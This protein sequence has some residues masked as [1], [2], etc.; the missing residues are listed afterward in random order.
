MS[1]TQATTS[2]HKNADGTYTALISEYDGGFLKSKHKCPDFLSELKARAGAHAAVYAAQ[3]MGRKVQTKIEGR[4][5][6]ITVSR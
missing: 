4:K 6:I 5:I 2:G 3:R 1:A